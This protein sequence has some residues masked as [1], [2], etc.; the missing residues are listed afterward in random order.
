[1]DSS[2]RPASRSDTPRPFSAATFTPTVAYLPAGLDGI[3]QRGSGFLEAF[4]VCSAVSAGRKVALLIVAMKIQLPTL[5][6]ERDGDRSSGRR[7]S[8]ARKSDA[9][10]EVD[11]GLT[12]FPSYLAG[13]RFD[14]CQ[15]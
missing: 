12:S 11:F 8:Q 4:Q 9:E 6:R 2:A 13:G 3:L 7:G 1:M 15:R 10:A 14:Q 5:L